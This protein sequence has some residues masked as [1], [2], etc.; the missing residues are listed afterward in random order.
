MLEVFGI[1]LFKHS[2]II[3][4]VH[5][6]FGKQCKTGINNRLGLDITTVIQLLVPAAAHLGHGLF[7]IKDRIVLKLRITSEESF[8]CPLVPLF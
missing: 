1:I 3:K 4:T 2:V 7:G 5:R 8:H 6:T